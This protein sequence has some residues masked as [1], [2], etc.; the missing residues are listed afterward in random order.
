MSPANLDPPG[1]DPRHVRT[2]FD[3]AIENR[4]QPADP[5]MLT[6]DPAELHPRDISHRSGIDVLFAAHFKGEHSWQMH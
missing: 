5:A 1:H 4:I 6:F 3:N 2:I